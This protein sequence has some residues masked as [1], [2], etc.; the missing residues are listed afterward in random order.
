M[1]RIYDAEEISDV[2]SIKFDVKENDINVLTIEAANRDHSGEYS[3]KIE[4][5]IGE[6]VSDLIYIDVQ[7][8]LFKN[9]K[10]NVIKKAR[11]LIKILFRPSY[12]WV[13]VGFRNFYRG[14][15]TGVKVPFLCKPRQQLLCYMVS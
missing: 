9:L 1:F 8:K 2:D 14:R 15:K 11:I 6:S 10:K 7:C 3:C 5:D 4:N 13:R 12:R